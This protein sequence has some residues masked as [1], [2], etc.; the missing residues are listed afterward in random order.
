[1][2]I[3]T[4]VEVTGEKLVGE[5]L[6]AH[7]LTA[8]SILNRVKG[9]IVIIANNAQKMKLSNKDFFSECNQIRSLLRTWLHLL[10]KP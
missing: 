5:S 9:K 10:N 1:M 8:S 4:F 6:F 3:P 2:L 7:P